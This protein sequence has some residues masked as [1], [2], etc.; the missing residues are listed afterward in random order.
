MAA[1]PYHAV[2]VVPGVQHCG[3]CLRLEGLR[4]LSG[5]APRLPL[6]GCDV[7]C[8]CIYQHHRDRREPSLLS[9]Y[10]HQSTGRPER[11]Q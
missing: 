11:R 7:R 3:A 1:E 4:F 6:P 10:F 8:R 5:E 9:S 2:S